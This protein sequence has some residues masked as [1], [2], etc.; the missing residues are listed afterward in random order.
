M[1]RVA[2][3][4]NA[5]LPIPNQ[6][7]DSFSRFEGAHS[8]L[9]SLHR[10]A[11]GRPGLWPLVDGTA[12]CRLVLRPILSNPIGRLAARRLKQRAGDQSLC[13]QLQQNWTVLA[14]RSV[15]SCSVIVEMD[16]SLCPRALTYD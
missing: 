16:K 4:G 7:V 1:P 9:R 6:A 13:G 3:C 11:A 10:G 8:A 5:F 12:S 14:F 2:Q 15:R